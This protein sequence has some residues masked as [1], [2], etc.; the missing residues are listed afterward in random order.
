MIYFVNCNWVD[1]R[2]QQ[3][4]THLH[5][6]STQ[7]DTKQT[8]HRTTQLLGRVWAVPR[9]CV[10]YPGFC[11]ATEEKARKN[12]S[13]GSRRVPAGTMK[14]YKLTIR[15]HRHNNEDTYVTLLN[16]EYNN[17]SIDKKKEYTSSNFIMSV[18]LLIMLDT[19]LL[20]PSLHCNTTPHFT[21]L[22]F[23]TTTVLKR[24]I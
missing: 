21:Q 1:T 7:K 5:T 17:I 9:L 18:C 20:R 14:I 8:I 4:C 19:L 24:V 6:N 23:T 22:H 15:I 3:F 2:W 12:L 16:Q 11:L 13:Q 10:L